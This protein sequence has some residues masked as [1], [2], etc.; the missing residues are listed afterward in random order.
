MLARGVDELERHPLVPL[1]PGLAIVI[2]GYIA[3]GIG[4]RL[5]DPIATGDSSTGG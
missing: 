4:R 2:T 5:E 3:A 1:V